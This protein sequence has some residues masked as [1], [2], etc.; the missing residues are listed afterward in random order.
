[1]GCQGCVERSGGVELPNLPLSTLSGVQLAPT[2]PK[3]VEGEFC[4]LFRLDGVLRGSLHA[5]RTALASD[6]VV[7]S[8]YLAS[9]EERIALCPDVELWVDV[10]TFEE[11]ASAARRSREPAAY[12]A[13]IQLYV[14]DLLPED[15][16]E[17]WAEGRRG[18]LVRTYLTLLV[19]LAGTYEERAEYDSAIEVLRKVVAEEPTSEEAHAGLMRL[20]ALSGSKGEALAQYVQ[21]EETLAKKLGA[22]PA[23]S[24][25]SLREEIAAGRFPPQKTPPLGSPSKKPPGAGKHNLPTPRTSFVGREREIEESKREL[26][27][28]RLLTFTGVGGS[29]KTRLA[30]EVARDLVGAYQDGVWLVEL[31]PLSEERLVPQAVARAMRVREQPGRP[32]IDTLT[33][34]LHKKSA[35]RSS[36]H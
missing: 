3:L 12:R 36:A 15:R 29:G 14:G 11:A 31:A 10:E 2:S 28:T 4:E 8:R 22:E 16:Y 20:Y 6:P 18:E 30:L 17:E 32:L 23:A 26:A 25:R 34:A 21:L 33:E 35:L 9:K 13:A 5:A 19:E 27:M 7:A 1:V 24:S